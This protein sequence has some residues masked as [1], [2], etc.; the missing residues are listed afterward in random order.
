MPFGRPPPPPTGL[1]GRSRSQSERGFDALWEIVTF[2][3][4]IGLA[5]EIQYGCDS[6]N[7]LQMCS[8]II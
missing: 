2:R 4:W 3:L 1:S 6:K 7:I 5:R 8:Y